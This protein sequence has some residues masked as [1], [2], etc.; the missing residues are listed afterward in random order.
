MAGAGYKLFNTGDVLT[1][2]QVNTY[3]QEQTVMVFASAAARTTAL[4]AVLAEGMV[5]FLKD[6]DSLEIYSGTAWV[7]YGSGDLTAITAGT[8]ITV[9]SGTGPIPTVALTTPVS[10]ANGG[11]GITSFG[12][13]IATFLGTPSS[14]NLA[15]ALT[16]ETGTGAAVFASSPTLVTPNL[17]TPSAATLT[18]A[19]GLPITAGTTGTLGETRGGTAQTTYTTGDLLYAS[20]TNTLAKRAIGTSGQVLTVSAGVPTWATPAGG[21][22]AYT[23]INS[24]GTSLSGT[25]TTVSSIGG[26]T[27][28][29]F[30]IEGAFRSSGSGVE[31]WLRFNSDSSANYAWGSFGS[32]NNSTANSG[33]FVKN[34]TQFKIGFRYGSSTNFNDGNFSSGWVYRYGSSDDKV[35]NVDTWGTDG[36]PNTTPFITHSRGAYNSSS[37]ITSITVGADSSLDG[38]KIFVYGVN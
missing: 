24:G 16:D 3:L 10:V 12:T 17:G 2:A 27:H 21:G 8:G 23:L 32:F 35:V 20:G 22:G 38:G 30:V 1:A 15:A 4:S 9:T 36:S 33:Q 11:T 14:A 19:T 7:S 28:L 6:T 37:G 26:Y 25:A 34:D 31:Y 5:T 18:N 13:G 29:F